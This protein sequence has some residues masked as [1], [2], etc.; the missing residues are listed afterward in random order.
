MSV[1]F[2][3][4][5]KKQDTPKVGVGIMFIHHVQHDP[6]HVRKILLM[7]R[8]GSHQ[9][10]KWA[11]PGGHMDIGEDFLTCCQREVKEEIG[12][13]LINIKKVCFENVIFEKE[14]LHYITLFFKATD[15][16]GVPNIMEH[17][18]CSELKWFDIDNIDVPVMGALRKALE[19]LKMETYA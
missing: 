5:K 18:K 12:V 7:K 16:R 4:M 10:E 6:Y 15:W 9:S 17:D 3:P 13:D 2:S 8:K 1:D 14:G 19:V 11:C